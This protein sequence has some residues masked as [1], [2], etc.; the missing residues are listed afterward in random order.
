MHNHLYRGST[1]DGEYSIIRINALS[2][3]FVLGPFLVNN[4][5][6]EYRLNN[7]HGYDDQIDLDLIHI[8]NPLLLNIIVC[9]II[10][11]NITKISIFEVQ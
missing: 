8:E 6:Q 9:T 11:M 1:Y 5:V 10:N 4:V 3:V 2:I 7:Q